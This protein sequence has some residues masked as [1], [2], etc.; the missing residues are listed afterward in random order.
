MAVLLGLVAEQAFAVYVILLRN[1][2]RL[3]AREKYEV[4]GANVIFTDKIG[5]LK[6]IPL[7][8][9]DVEATEKIN[10]L[11]LGDAQALDWVDREQIKP[12]PT[13]TPS[14]TGLGRVRAGVVKVNPDSVR[15]TPTPGIMYRDQEYPDRQVTAAFASGFEAYHIYLYRMSLGTQPTYLFI[16]VQVNGQ[17]ET[18]KA[19]QAVTTTY[20]LLSQQA[21]SRTPERV[22]IQMLNESGREAGLFRISAAEAAELATGKVTPEN[23]FVQ[24]VIF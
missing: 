15:P 8:Q 21:P 18:L 1:G 9:V 12:T 6:S 19:L 17:A 20:Y 14:M 4:K 2:G 16:E 7:V 5:T 3:V 23:Y 11:G 10:K 24:H 13:P 22:E